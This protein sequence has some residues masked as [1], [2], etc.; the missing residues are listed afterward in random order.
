MSAGGSGSRLTRPL[1]VVALVAVATLVLVASGSKAWVTGMTSDA[2]L[3]TSHVSATGTESVPGV[4]GLALVVLAAAVA[5]A[6]AGRVGRVVALVAFGIATVAL[7]VD[8]VS[9][10]LDPDSALGRAV[11]HQLGRTGSVSSSGHPTAWAYAATG[12]LVLLVLAL[13]LA[14]LGRRSWHGLSERYDKAEAAGEG[15]ATD[16]AGR[17]GERARTAWQQL[18]EGHD[19][20][21]DDG[22]SR[23]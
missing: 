6:T 20:T 10:L 13:G 22:P 18:S 4:V 2:V 5:A 12:A 7:A 15:A 9:F 1:P 23:S 17:R 19:P 21:D 8:V 14:I 16:V 3:G 11:A